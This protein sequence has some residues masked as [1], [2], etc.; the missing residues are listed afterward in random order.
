MASSAFHPGYRKEATMSMPHNYST[1][2]TNN[3]MQPQSP[4]TPPQTVPMIPELRGCPCGLNCRLGQCYRK[5]FDEL[6][7]LLC[8]WD[9]CATI[10]VATNGRRTLEP[11]TGRRADPPPPA[12]RLEIQGSECAVSSSTKSGPGRSEKD[13]EELESPVGVNCSSAIQQF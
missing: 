7:D 8:D 6:V 3:S 12:P 4:S 5:H 9:E 1:Q 11:M 13:D 10:T 2:P